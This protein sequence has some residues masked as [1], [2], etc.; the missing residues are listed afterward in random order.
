MTWAFN[1]KPTPCRGAVKY[2]TA[3]I[4]SIHLSN[5]RQCSEPPNPAMKSRRFISAL[6]RFV[7]KPI[8]IRD[9]LEP[10]L[11][12]SVDAPAGQRPSNAI[13]GS[14]PVGKGV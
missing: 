11:M 10:V 14:G 13:P 9:A 8:A 12:A 6:R 1:E 2:W 4:R 3:E 5:P 7:A